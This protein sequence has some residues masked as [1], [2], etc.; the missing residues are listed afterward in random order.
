MNIRRFS[1]ADQD[2]DKKLKALL[3]FETAQDDSIDNVVAG[4]LK[5]V[6]ARGDQAVLEYTQKFDRLD[7]PN[8]QALELSKEE[9]QQALDSLPAGQREALQ[10][11]A[12]RVRKYHEKQ[13]MTSWTYTEEDGTLLG[14]QVTR[15]EERRVG[16]TVRMMRSAR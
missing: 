6:K 11:A 7:V 8:M 3:A 5:D 9:L 16:K 4:I 12:S 2:F 10:E 14:Q 1:T 15:S 13:L